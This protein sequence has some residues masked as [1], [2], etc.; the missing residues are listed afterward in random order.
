MEILKVFLHPPLCL[1]KICN[2]KNALLSMEK[3]NR[4]DYL[5]LCQ[6]EASGVN[7]RIKIY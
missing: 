2:Q 5:F 4:E 6:L 3:S 7:L 1:H